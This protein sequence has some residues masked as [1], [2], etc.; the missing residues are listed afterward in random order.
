MKRKNKLIPLLVLGAAT[1]CGGSGS[2][3]DGGSI[4]PPPIS[5]SQRV[6]GYDIAGFTGIAVNGSFEMTVTQAAMYSVE[7]TIDADEAGKLDVRQ[8][9][10][11]LS[12][13]FLPGSDVRANTLRAIVETPVLQELDLSGSN[14]VETAGFSGSVFH[15]S[16]NGSNVLESVGLEFDLITADAFGNSLLDFTNISPVPGAYF[17]LS[18]S[19]T[20]VI[21]LMNSATVTGALMG[22][23]ALS[24]YGSDIFF[25]M[26]LA[27]T[28][29]VTRLGDTR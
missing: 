7:I 29:S 27:P 12:I 22:T 23:S 20:A 4:E 25:D 11:N 8:D 28:A 13:G 24:Y 14:V 15:V 5:S 9:G 10:S 1:A 26:S 3:S 6:I 19:T 16:S 2:G 21:N 17:E 18:G